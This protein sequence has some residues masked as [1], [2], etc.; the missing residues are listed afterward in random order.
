MKLFR[1]SFI[2]LVLIIAMILG[3]ACQ[4]GQKGSP[5]LIDD[6]DKNTSQSGFQTMSQIIYLYPSPAEMLSAFDM[7]E[8]SYNGSLLNPIER[9]EL[10]LGSSLKTYALGVYVTDLAYA[11]LFG[12]HEETLN[13]LEQVQSLAED[14]DINQA[15]DE[16]M[17]EKARDNVNYLDSLYDISNDAF[18]NILRFCE[19][20]QRSNTVVL[21]TAG[22]ITES[23]Y[24]AVHMVDD[25]GTADL[26]LQQLSD[27]KYTVDNFM[28]F[29]SSLK[30][31]DPEVISV[32]NDLATIKE[33]FDG[34][35][36]GTGGVTIKPAADQD[37]KQPKKLVIGGSG[38]KSQPHLS[39]EEFMA[40]KQAVIELRNNAV[41]VNL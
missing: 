14:V 27:Q 30:S 29:A 40:L 32:L 1:I 20:D 28:L 41:I 24:L 38:S 33:I 17:I 5:V 21:L 23:L 10:Y 22:A 6:V 15:V 37:E 16:S 11:A 31:D 25:Y 4:S 12:R 7:S 34:I 26:L 36:P 9:A 13:Y 18:I 19:K 2:P 39:E 35:E 3:S 8:L